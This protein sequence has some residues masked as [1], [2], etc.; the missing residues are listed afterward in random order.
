MHSTTLECKR[1]S[2]CE[3]QCAQSMSGTLCKPQLA[4]ATACML[5]Q[6]TSS[7][8]CGESGLA[9]IKSSFC[10]AAQKAFIDCMIAAVPR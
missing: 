4:A 5:K 2:E 3:A 10:D 8:E 7:W 6:P 1:A 9:S